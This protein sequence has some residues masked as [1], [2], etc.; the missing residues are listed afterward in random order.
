MNKTTR[1]V[2]IKSIRDIPLDTIV[3]QVKV[4][5][6]KEQFLY[7][8]ETYTKILDE[9]VSLFRSLIEHHST[10]FVMVYGQNAT[11]KEKY[12]RFQT[13]WHSQC[14]IFLMLN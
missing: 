13:E 2:I 4:Q 8:R 10:T 3:E 12:L 1:N 11:G 14:S 9:L 5:L 6:Y 7:N